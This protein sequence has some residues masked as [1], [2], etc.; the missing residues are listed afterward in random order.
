MNWSAVTP[1]HLKPWPAL[2]AYHANLHSVPASRVFAEERALY[3]RELAQRNA[4]A[5]AAAAAP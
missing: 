1:V 5:P 4:P 2:R 3:M